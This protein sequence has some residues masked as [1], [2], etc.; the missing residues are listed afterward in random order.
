MGFHGNLKTMHLGDVFQN[1]LQNRSA[2]NLRIQTSEMGNIDLFFMEGELVLYHSKNLEEIQWS[3]V[4]LAKGDLT[5]EEVNMIESQGIKGEEELAGIISSQII[6]EEKAAINFQHI[7]EEEIYELFF[8]QDCDFSFESA[9]EVPAFYTY[10][11]LFKRTSF[12][13]NMML[14][15]AARRSDE[16]SQEGNISSHEIFIQVQDK[17]KAIRA[18]LNEEEWQI[19]DLIDGIR[20]VSEILRDS[21]SKR[22]FIVKI[23]KKF[24]ELQLIKISDTKDLLAKASHLASLQDYDSA[25]KIYRRL[26]D[27][28]KAVL[29]HRE[30][31]A[32]T[33]LKLQQKDNAIMQLEIMVSEYIL[34]KDFK[35]ANDGYEKILEID[36]TKLNI[37]ELIA[38]NYIELGK[39]KDAIAELK[40]VLQLYIDSGVFER[41]KE[42]CTKLLSIDPE[43]LK[44]MDLLAK[45]CVS[46]GERAQAVEVWNKMSEIYMSRELNDDAIEIFKKIMKVEPS[47]DRAKELLNKLMIKMG[48]AKTRQKLFVILGSI[49]IFIILLASGIF[50]RDQKV[51]KYLEELNFSNSEI[52]E[53]V[54]KSTKEKEVLEKTDEVIKSYETFK[55]ENPYSPT[56]F[57]EIT[58]L[59]REVERVKRKKLEEFR[60]SLIDKTNQLEVEFEEVMAGAMNKK[61]LASLLDLQTYREKIKDDAK[62]TEKL[63]QID[64]KIKF[65]NSLENEANGIYL[66]ILELIKE[67]NLVEANKLGKKILTDFMKTSLPDKI[68]YYVNLSSSEPDS[69]LIINGEVIARSM[70]LIHSYKPNETIKISIQKD[71]YYEFEDEVKEGNKANLNAIMKRKVLWTYDLQ[72]PIFANPVFKDGVLFLSSRNGR[73]VALTLDFNADTYKEVWSFKMTF[74]SSD[75]FAA[76]YF[77]NDV[78]YVGSSDKHI[79][80]IDISAGR[81]YWKIKMAGAVNSAVSLAKVS[82]KQEQKMLFAVSS[83]TLEE[84]NLVGLDAKTGN[85]EWQR[86]I[87]GRAFSDVLATS[88]KVYVGTDQNKIIVVRSSTGVPLEIVGKDNEM[89]PLEYKSFGQFKGTFYLREIDD[90]EYIMASSIDQNIY[91]FDEKTGNKIWNFQTNSPNGSGVNLDDQNLYNSS[92]DGL[93]TSIKIKESIKNKKAIVNWS[94][95]YDGFKDPTQIFITENILYVGGA[96]ENKKGKLLA[97]RKVDGKLLWTLDTP[98]PIN[99]RPLVVESRVIVGCDDNKIYVLKE[100][101]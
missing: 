99:C 84:G 1:I 8:I 24:L 15:E 80:A 58:E 34:R 11:T 30:L 90:L 77:D 2:G 7:I 47:N 39:K 74:P 67:N 3:R 27:T 45:T 57:F 9:T 93:I 50:Y 60:K 25:A 44:V 29:G 19:Y 97:I 92:M 17:D 73:I 65:L 10:T 59:I 61:V 89:I 28:E 70:P 38:D 82:L 94:T 72:N 4:L 81:E 69:K 86:K 55:V 46:R 22:Q 68:L 71:G 33:F 62:L 98:M 48:K 87:K 51:K 88:S 40:H 101:K 91:C 31:L 75:I 36:G 5:E 78:V 35:K 54:A 79:Y 20:N 12:N 23:L 37:R 21:G 96:T 14:M 52:M 16:H 32:E 6:G 64:E 100:L 41:A 13:T 83:D 56:V 43:D 63:N 49:L 53:K 42:V 26:V 85:N 95:K 18:N 66:K 76:G